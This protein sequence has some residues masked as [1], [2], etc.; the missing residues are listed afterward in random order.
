M[1]TKALFSIIVLFILPGMLMS[2]IRELALPDD[3]ICIEEPAS[4]NIEQEIN[5]ELVSLRS[6]ISSMDVQIQYLDRQ[7]MYIEDMD[8]YSRED[9]LLDNYLNNAINYGDQAIDAAEKV[10]DLSA[11]FGGIIISTVSTNV[12]LGAE[13]KN[14]ENMMEQM[15]ANRQA[16]STSFENFDQKADQLYNMMSAILKMMN[17]MKSQTLRNLL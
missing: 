1:K 7:L 15:R 4:P 14:V 10:I 12:D 6:K 3:D 16:A 5:L 11:A 17:E 9:V 8:S 13:I 2:Q